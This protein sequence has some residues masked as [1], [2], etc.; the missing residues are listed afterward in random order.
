M[1]R[2]ENSTFAIFKIIFGMIVYGSFFCTNLVE[3]RE[4]IIQLQ[5]PSYYTET[6]VLTPSVPVLRK[7][8]FVEATQNANVIIGSPSTT[9]KVVLIDSDGNRHE[10]NGVE[11]LGV[12]PFIFPDPSTPNITGTNYIFS[13][14]QPKP[15]M[16]VYE[17]TTEAQTV[18]KPTSILFTYF[19]GNFIGA[20]IVGGG[21]E[22]PSG[23][24]ISLGIIAVDGNVPILNY[25]ID[26]TVFKPSD[27]MFT[28]INVNFKDDGVSPDTSAKDGL[29]TATLNPSEPGLF[30]INAVLTGTSLSTGLPFQRTAS[31]TFRVVLQH[32]SLDGT[33]SDHG[34]DD[35]GNGLFDRIIIS[36]D[37]SIVDAGRYN[38]SVLLTADNGSVVSGNVV[39]D[40]SVGHYKL[41]VSFTSEEIKRLGVPG[42]YHV[43][44][45]QAEWL[46]SGVADITDVVYD[47]GDTLPYTMNQFER[48]PIE[49]SGS[50]NDYGIDTNGNSKYDLLQVNV[51]VNV[52]A[53]GFYQWSARL[54]DSN[55]NEIGLASKSG[56]LNTG[57]NAIGL[58]FDGKKIGLNGQNGPY[59]LRDLLIYGAG[60][61][62]IVNDVG[63]TQAYR[64]TAFE[65]A[66]QSPIAQCQN[67]TISAN[68]S[69]QA[70][71]SVDNGSYDP[72]GDPITLT[73]IP[74]GPYSLGSAG[75]TL[76]ATDPEGASASCT[77]TVTV[78]DT[79][80]PV[81]SSVTASPNTLWPPNHKMMPVQVTA[82][83]LDNCTA[84]PVCKIASV[85][86]NE[87]DNGLG[88]GDT[89]NDIVVTGDLTVNL[90]AERSG[91]GTGRLYTVNGQCTDAAGNVA[92]WSTTVTVPHDQGK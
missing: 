32:A 75:V 37:I 50:S 9:L 21:E 2:L 89:A 34:V 57:N 40:L 13:L 62:L 73:Q 3:A 45:I 29:Y 81:I 77:G 26:A 78:K 69:C 33:F 70:N 10:A 43:S 6:A 41:D 31:S 61:S 20:T 92:S 52:L 51:N 86:S 90:R 1:M 30:Q 14:K 17:I 16:W 83:I 87:P 46:Q 24:A 15:G 55:G 27:T 65:G 88:D 68:G 23:K 49:I 76:T 72:E 22:Y 7:S 58:S 35:N 54:V 66:N 53:S 19:P 67:V 85:T 59:V 18:V 80:A 42:P 38:V 47:L 56:M 11:Q 79:T 63:T 71:A 39:K 12:T 60:N 91:T 82:A 5:L 25:S 84:A 28:P 48:G 74:V 4:D 64:F 44:Q 8:F 36:S